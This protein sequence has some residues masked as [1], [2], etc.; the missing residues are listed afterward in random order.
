VIDAENIL[1]CAVTQE[2]FKKAPAKQPTAVSNELRHECWVLEKK[3]IGSRSRRQ[4]Y[5]SVE[6]ALQKDFP[7]HF[8]EGHRCHVLF[9][10]DPPVS[11][12]CF[13]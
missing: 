12:G 4:S 1:D 7:Q 2:L 6:F 13:A 5:V 8:S 3:T 11:V 9:F 10:W